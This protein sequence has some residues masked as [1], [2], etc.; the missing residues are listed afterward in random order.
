MASRTAPDAARSLGFLSD[1]HGNLPALEAVL[2]ELALREVE[3][4]YVAGDLLL[5]G[6]Q[7]LEVWNR[8][9]QAGAHCTRGPSDAALATVDPATLQPTDDDEERRARQFARTR[10]ALGDI[11]LKR[12]GRLPEQLR[13]STP[14]GVELLV[15]HGCP[16]DPF[17]PISHDLDD[18]EVRFLLGDDSADIVVCGGS[19]VYF[20]REIDGVRIIN[21]GS[22]G[23]SPAGDCADYAVVTSRDGDIVIEHG[24]AK[25]RIGQATAP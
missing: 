22:V 1:I 13:L 12:L 8:L 2:S 19:H 16:R 11:I 15:V 20:E 25:Y 6:D 17:L 24:W 23:E 10:E 18:D 4:I 3:D 14:S 9:Q 5:G 21:V 7:P